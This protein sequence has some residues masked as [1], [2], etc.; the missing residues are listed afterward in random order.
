MMVPTMAH[1]QEAGRPR[2]LWS[3]LL[4]GPR[5]LTEATAVAPIPKSAPNGARPMGPEAHGAVLSPQ[6][7]LET[8]MAPSTW[9]HAATAFESCGLPTELVKNT[10]I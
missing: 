6:R 10:T 2:R 8:G 1:Q 3:R 5:A 7:Y 4:G 9:Q